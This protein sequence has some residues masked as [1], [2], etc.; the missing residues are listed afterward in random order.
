[1]SAREVTIRVQRGNGANVAKMSRPREIIGS[2]EGVNWRI[3]DSDV[4]AR[5]A[6]LY[7]GEGDRLWI[8]PLAGE[9][10]VDGERLDGPLPVREGVP[11]R[12]GP[13]IVTA[14]GLLPDG[15]VPEGALWTLPPATDA[16]IRLEE[17]L[18]AQLETLDADAAQA[19][20][21]R[22]ADRVARLHVARALESA[23]FLDAATSVRRVPAV[24][25][26]DAAGTMREHLRNLDDSVQAELQR[27]KDA[28]EAKGEALAAGRLALAALRLAED[29]V[30]GAVTP[31]TGRP[32][33][34]VTIGFGEDS[35]PPPDV[36]ETREL[37]ARPRAGVV[38]GRLVDVAR[39]LDAEAGALTELR[40]LAKEIAD[41]RRAG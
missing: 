31:Y 40:L 13:A 7:V 15:R 24:A 26:L 30:R 29:A 2:G 22:W 34:A 25:D 16:E 17:E 27:R 38:A 36:R 8:E 12:I 4:E 41:A 6:A 11:I 32:G 33:F 10:F 35:D 39:T 9:T 1:M 5:H 14:T 19:L 37:H 3:R 20:A 23:A 28:G 18:D 21:W